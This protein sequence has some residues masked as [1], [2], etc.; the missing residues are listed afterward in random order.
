FPTAWT[1]APT[2]KED[3]DANGSAA[4]VLALLSRLEARREAKQA[5]SARYFGL[6]HLWLQLSTVGTAVV[7]AATSPASTEILAVLSLI[8]LGLN[9]VFASSLEAFR[10][11][12]GLAAA[13][14]SLPDRGASA[15]AQ[16]AVEETT[17]PSADRLS[18]QESGDDLLPAAERI[19]ALDLRAITV[20]WEATPVID[21][22]DLHAERGGWT[23][24]CGDS[25]TGKSTSLSVI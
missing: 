20:G 2:A 5:A 22:L 3:V 14:D 12:P 21:G 17:A 19:E 10:Q 4:Q 18:D 9:E 7:L 6:A 16:Q 8:A 13:L 25:G 1:R 11:M 15:S 24:L 23:L